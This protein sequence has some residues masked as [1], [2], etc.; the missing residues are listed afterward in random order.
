MLVAPGR[1][2]LTTI[3]KPSAVD[4]TSPASPVGRLALSSRETVRG[5]FRALPTHRRHGPNRLGVAGGA[6]IFESSV[7]DS[8]RGNATGSIS[9]PTGFRKPS[10]T[11]KSL[12]GTGLR[13]ADIFG[14]P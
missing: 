5:C 13:G 4:I 9:W 1:L 2:P 6:S 8:R 10:D 11:E 7:V 14:A 3:A 12:P